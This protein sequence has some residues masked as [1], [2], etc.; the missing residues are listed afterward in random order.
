LVDSNTNSNKEYLMAIRHGPAA[1]HRLRA[2]LL[3]TLCALALGPAVPARATDQPDSALR[4]IPADVSFYASILRGREQIERL[5]HSN[6]WKK[7][8]DLPLVKMGLEHLHAQLEQPNNPQLAMLLQLA[9]QPDNQKLL[10]LLRDMVSDEVFLYGGDNFVKFIELAQAAQGTMNYGPAFAQLGGQAGANLQE[11][12]ILR[13]LAKNLDL[14]QVPDLVIGFRLKDTETAE[15]QILRLKEPLEKLVEQVP[16]LKGHVHWGKGGNLLQIM[17][18]GSLLPRDELAAKLKELEDKEDEFQPLLKKLTALKLTLNLGVREH[19]VLLS[20]GSSSEAASKLGSGQRLADRPEFGPLAQ[21]RDKPLTGISY[22]SAGLRSHIGTTRRDIDNLMQMVKDYAKKSD[23]PAEQQDRLRKD[24]DE[25]A[26]DAQKFFPQ[27]GPL[28]AFS[29]LTPQGGENYSYDHSEHAN[30]IGSKPLGLLHHVGGNPV[31]AVVARHKS[32]LETYQLL[33][34]WA[35]KGY[36]YVEELVVPKLDDN[37]KG[38]FEMATKV[39][40]PFLSKVDKATQT[41]FF[42]A[43]EDG[44]IAFVLDAKIKSKQWH[45][46]LPNM[47][48]P[49]A[50]AEPALVL[51]VSDAAKLRQAFAVYREAT[52]ELIAKFR[53]SMPIVPEFEIP[54]PETAKVNGGTL[55]YYTLPEAAGLDKQIVLA[56]G[57][58]DH[59]AVATISRSHAERLLANTPLQAS[60]GPLAEA[61]RPLASAVYFNWGALITAAT[62]WIELGVQTGLAQRGEARPTAAEIMPQ[63]GVLLDV[64]KCFRTYTS[65]SYFEGKV[66]VTHGESVFKDL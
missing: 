66:L 18:D 26:K 54:P 57:L 9:Q 55:Y 52:N 38:M 1:P 20:F 36:G 4:L 45:E 49:A 24:L 31:L 17:L 65:A 25:L 16:Q 37:Q 47:E 10:H 3:F 32:G 21:H 42:P 48:K 43:L 61:N 35:K 33:V 50:L 15:A 12:L 11:K 56:A 22:L 64:L 8:H 34:K 27:A 29:F 5:T 51:G 23:L 62:P 59:V 58:S 40:L 46:K 14:I 60:Q 30:P 39:L 53:E 41:L 13:V 7:L 19:Y 28:V 2:G 63:L 44:Q 6:A